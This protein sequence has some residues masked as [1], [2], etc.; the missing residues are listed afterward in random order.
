VRELTAKR[1]RDLLDYDPVA[2]AFTWRVARA[3]KTPKGRRAGCTSAGKL[4]IGIDR[5]TYDA[6]R[7]VFLHQDGKW[8]A[9]I[10]RARNGALTDIRRANLEQCSWSD[11]LRAIDSAQANNKLGVRGVARTAAR[12]GRA[13][14]SFV[15]RVQVDGASRHIGSFATLEGAALAYWLAKA[16][17]ALAET[18]FG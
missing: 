8:P 5:R 14:N 15:A 18:D 4:R 6:H 3:Y 13:G 1:L 17:L 10:V 7:L 16:F 9:E 12:G 2:G 11:F